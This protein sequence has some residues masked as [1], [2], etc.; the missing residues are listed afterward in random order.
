MAKSAQKPGYRCAECGWQTAKW[1]GRCGE[2]Q[3]WGTVDEA[4]AAPARASSRRAGERARA[5]PIG[6]VDAEAAQRAPDRRRAS[7]TACSAAASCP[8]R[9]CCSPA[10]PASASR[11]C[12]WRSPRR[13]AARGTV[14]YVT[15]EESAAQVRLRADRIGARRATGSTSPPRPTC[16]PCSGHVEQVAA[17]RCWSSTRSRRSAPPRSTAP[18]A[19]SRQVREVAADLI[20]VAKER[21]I[22]TRARRPRHQG[23]LDR[24]AA[25]AGAPGRRRAAS[26]RATGTRRLRMV[27][28]VKNRYGPTDEVG[29]FDLS[30]A[31]IAG[32]PTR[33]ACSSPAAPSRCPAPASRSRWRAAARCV[34]EVQ[35]LVAPHRGPEPTPRRPPGSTPAASRWCW[36]CWSAGCGVK[37]GRPRRLRRDRRRRPAQRAGGRPR[38]RARRRRRGQRPARCRR[39]WSRSARWAWP[40]RCGA[41]HGV[42]RRLAEAARL[43][44]TRALVPADSGV[45]ST[46]TRRHGVSVDASRSTSA[47]VRTLARGFDVRRG[48]RTRWAA[49]HTGRP[50]G[51]G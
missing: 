22:A 49:R 34:A 3:A 17:R 16:R 4:G 1:V 12:C 47:P 40:A 10:S 13:T 45:A 19:A 21:G 18:P 27:R 20:R 37:L 2:C 46:G 43:G 50:A 6:E 24:R 41:V 5:R 14:L 8:A 42:R 29:C 30:D 23:R 28:A 7:S 25:R 44:F 35:A 26:S 36:R 15:G 33:A 38:R 51:L 39:A 48:G 11:R 32:C 9:W 31:G